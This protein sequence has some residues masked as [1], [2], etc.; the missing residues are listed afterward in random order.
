MTLAGRSS[1]RGGGRRW[2]I[3]GLVITLLV[4]LVDA[5]IKSRSPTP[6]RQLAAQT[7]VDRALGIVVQSNVQGADLTGLRTGTTSGLTAGR[8]TAD[9]AAMT[10]GATAAY[11]DYEK[12]REPDLLQSSAGLLQTCLLVR[13]QAAATIATAVRTSLQDKS[14]PTTATSAQDFATAVEQLEVADQAYRLFARSLPRRYDTAPASAWIGDPGLYTPTGLQVYLTALQSR[15]SLTPVHLLSIVSVGT[16][17]GPIRASGPGQPY[18]VLS[19]SST[20]TVTVVIG[21]IGNQPEP[22]LDATAGISRSTGTASGHEI[23]GLEPGGATTVTFSGLTP[24]LGKVVT[25]TVTVTPPTGSVTKPVTRSI[26]FEMPSPTSSTTTTVPPPSTT[27]PTTTTTTV[28]GQ[29][30][31][32]PPA[33]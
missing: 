16:T 19:P 14:A 32:T 6:G 27:L 22:N 7:W 21:D 23:I 24:P 12:L 29:T 1:R 18:E 4:L 8:V 33:T 30:T 15:V 28:P 5:S 3:V 25:L 10:S 9:L 2:L 26:Q 17:P 20:L 11:A 13:K 31:T